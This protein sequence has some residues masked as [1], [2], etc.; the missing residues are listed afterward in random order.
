MLV[1]LLA[2]V[3]AL[4]AM[5]GAQARRGVPIFEPSRVTLQR[6]DGKNTT[7]EDVRRAIMTGTQPF[8]WVV[9]QDAPGLVQIR[10]TKE[11]RHWAQVRISYDASS[12]QISYVATSESLKHSKDDNG[13]TVIHP[14]YNLWV[15]NLVARIMVPGEVVPGSAMAQPAAA[16]PAASH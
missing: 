3:M 4:F 9:E 10:Y 8:G 15:R 5:V 11:G 6:M 1:R 14:T 7:T 13:Q 16:A 12:Y 2:L